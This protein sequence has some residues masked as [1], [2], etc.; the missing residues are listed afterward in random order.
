MDIVSVDAFHMK[1]IVKFRIFA[2]VTVHNADD[3]TAQPM[4]A[5]RV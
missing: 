1:Q 3:C 5:L 4:Q 2:I